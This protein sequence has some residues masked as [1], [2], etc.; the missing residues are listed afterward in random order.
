MGL[1]AR[2]RSTWWN[3]IS[4]PWC[5]SSSSRG[6][7]T[8]VVTHSAVVVPLVDCLSSSFHRVICATTPSLPLSG[9]HAWRASEVSPDLP[10]Q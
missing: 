1:A 6:S 3:R 8:L 5:P 2:Q 9:V 4:S 7:C 10:P